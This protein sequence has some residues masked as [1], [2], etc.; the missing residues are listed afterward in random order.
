[1]KTF[2][3]TFCVEMLKDFTVRAPDR[4]TAIEIAWARY[5]RWAQ[6]DRAQS[7][8]L[9]DAVL[10]DAIPDEARWSDQSKIAP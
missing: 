5:E 10:Y 6:T 2:D 3:I 7:L 8:M 4:D 9:G 1:M